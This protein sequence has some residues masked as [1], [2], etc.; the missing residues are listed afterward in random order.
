MVGDHQWHGVKVGPGPRIPLQSLKVGPETLLMFKS[1]THI[2]ALL[3]C[4]TYYILHEFK[5]I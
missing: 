4:F 1:G 5:Q 3:Y 2:I